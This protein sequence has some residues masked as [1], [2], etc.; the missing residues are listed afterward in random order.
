GILPIFQWLISLERTPQPTRRLHNIE[1]LQGWSMLGF[2]PLEQLSYLI[3]KDV[4]PATLPSVKSLYDSAAPPAQVDLG[5]L[6]VLSCRFW[7]AYVVLQFAH[8]EEDRKLLIMKHRAYKRA[9]M[10]PGQ[11]KELRASWDALFN[12]FIANLGY[13]PMTIHYS[14]EK[15]LFRNDTWVAFFGWIAAVAQFYSAWKAT[16]LP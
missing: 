13:L 3:S 10:T 8:M 11:K 1:R 14:L 12:Q 2:F 15:G 9:G 4:V 16:A 6:G 5:R 7:A